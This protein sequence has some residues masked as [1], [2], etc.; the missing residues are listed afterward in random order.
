MTD[1]EKNNGW[2]IQDPK[3]TDQLAEGENAGPGK[4][5]TKFEYGTKQK[6]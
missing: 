6:S 2:K 1:Q 5:R 3:M 4:L